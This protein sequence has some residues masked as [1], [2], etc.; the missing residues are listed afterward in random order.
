MATPLVRFWLPLLVAEKLACA[1]PS[2][3]VFGAMFAA[4]HCKRPVNRA[5]RWFGV[6][7]KLG[8]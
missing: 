6:G 1:D 3:L 8:G 7:V 5:F 2:T 4:H